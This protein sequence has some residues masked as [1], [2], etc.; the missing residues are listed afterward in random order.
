MAPL[1]GRRTAEMVGL[2][3]HLLA[4]GLLIA[5]QAIDLRDAGP[6]GS[7]AAA[8]HALV[9]ERA[10]FIGSEDSIPSDLGPLVELVR[11][12]SLGA[13]L[14]RAAVRSPAG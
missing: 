10:A 12:A 11:S 14:P 8:C 7:G 13:L 9:R 2:G 1:S 3:E 5:A 4:T 6:L